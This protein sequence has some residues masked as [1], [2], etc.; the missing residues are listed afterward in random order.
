MF[1]IL[2]SSWYQY[3]N[4][5]CHLSIT[6][7]LRALTTQCS[8]VHRVCEVCSWLWV[9]KSGLPGQYLHVALASPAHRSHRA[10]RVL[11]HWPPGLRETIWS[12]T[13]RQF[14]VFCFVMDGFLK[15]GPNFSSRNKTS[16]QSCRTCT[17]ECSAHTGKH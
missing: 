11:L 9:C 13:L 16:L 17:A 15:P 5:S 6:D 3:D 10:A 7:Q 1:G 8:G 4:R 14:Y 2:V 12:F